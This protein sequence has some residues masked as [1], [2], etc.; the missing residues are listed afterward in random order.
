MYTLCLIV[1]NKLLFNDEFLPSDSTRRIYQKRLAT[2]MLKNEKAYGEEEEEE[3]DEEEEEEEEEYSDDE[4]GKE[5][6]YI[7][8][9]IL[10]ETTI[11]KKSLEHYQ[12]S[13]KSNVY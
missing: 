9:G 12:A 7:K 1:L 6:M 8:Q 11:P 13:L 2:L 3:V 4:P 5:P 10:R